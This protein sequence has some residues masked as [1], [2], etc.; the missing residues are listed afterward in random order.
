MSRALGTAAAAQIAL[1]LAGCAPAPGTDIVP[2]RTNLLLVVVDTLRADHLGCYGYH[3]P[4]SP[5]IDRLASDGILFKKAIS[6][7][8]WT[9]PSMA[10]LLTGSYPRQTGVFKERFDRLPEDVVTLA[11]MHAAAGYTTC[12]VTANP[13]INSAFGFG[14]G[15]ASWHDSDVGWGWMRGMDE[16][17]DAGVRLGAGAE[18]PPAEVVTDRALKL[19]QGACESPFYLQ[20]LYIDPHTPYRP[21]ASFEHPLLEGAATDSEWYDAE[22]AY[23]DR[24]VGRLVDAVRTAHPDTLIVVTS[25]HGEGL[26]DHPE[27]AGAA[28]H[29][30][31]LYDSVLHVPL[32]FQHPALEGGRRVEEMVQLLD[33]VPTVAELLDLRLDPRVRGRSLVSALHGRPLDAPID[34]V[35]SETSFKWVDK[36]SVRE[37][38]LKLVVNRDHLLWQAGLRPDLDEDLGGGSK[39]KQRLA[40]AIRLS[41]PV[42]LYR[43]PGLEHPTHDG[44]N[45]ADDGAGKATLARLEAAIA[46][47]EADVPARAPI[48]RAAE[49]AASSGA[50][51]DE[52]V[53]R[54]LEA[55]GYL[56]GD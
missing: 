3:Q 32:L 35:F 13:N 9:R 2:G 11:E 6:N 44:V 36:V 10:S 38:G 49:G 34:R 16:M 33:L 19:L 14:Q 45:L 31:T 29:G 17:R 18:L 23:V 26:G 24:E 21:P 27:V 55:L 7:C 46:E 28:T 15:F 1:F 42:E 51:V 22:I 41:G 20:L 8:S 52:T 53:L 4:T 43:L 56:D 50:V 40:S 5:N 48:G 12:G 25:D 39:Q 54:Q 37:D 47:F 30:Y